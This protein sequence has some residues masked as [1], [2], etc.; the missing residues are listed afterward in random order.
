MW[1]APGLLAQEPVAKPKS[2]LE[3]MQLAIEK[4]RKSVRRQVSAPDV[5]TNGF[6]SLQWTGAAT[7]SPPS[8]VLVAKPA[9]MRWR[10]PIWMRSSK[11]RRLTR[12]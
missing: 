12:V 11:N 8:G 1:I 3:A 2:S 10:L 9:A 5:P 4:Q 6:F 7:L